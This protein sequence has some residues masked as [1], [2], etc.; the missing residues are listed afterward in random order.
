MESAMSLVGAIM[1]NVVRWDEQAT[2]GTFCPNKTVRFGTRTH[3]FV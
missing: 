3:L 1:R 2:S